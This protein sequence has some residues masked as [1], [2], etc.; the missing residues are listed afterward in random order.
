MHRCELCNTYL[1]ERNKTKHNQTKKHKYYSNL[2]LNRY[3]IKNVEVK[4]FKDVI[5]P[6][7][8]A[9]TRKFNF[10]TVSILLRLYDEGHLLSHKISVSNYVTYS[11]QSEHYI[12]YTT[13]LANDFLYRVLSIFFLTEVSLK[14]LLK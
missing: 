13:E 10:F 12:T 11:I 1:L 9:H 8:T 2:K 6:Y 7:F 14:E 3:V 5:N 4:K